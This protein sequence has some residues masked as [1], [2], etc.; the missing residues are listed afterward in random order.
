MPMAAGVS[1]GGCE[2]SSSFDRQRPAVK[3]R[4]PSLEGSSDVLRCNLA[5]G[6]LRH[7]KPLVPGM[8]VVACSWHCAAG[9]TAGSREEPLLT[10]V[11]PHSN[12]ILVGP[13][14]ELRHGSDGPA[15]EPCACRACGLGQRGRGA[16]MSLTSYPFQNEEQRQDKIEIAVQSRIVGGRPCRQALPCPARFGTIRR[17]CNQ[18]AA[19]TRKQP[20]PV[21]AR[22]SRACTPK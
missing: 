9:S 15:W 19:P 12:T 10:N 1:V 5:R 20:T 13:D 4:G 22:D 6:A 17:P 8:G 21:K 3:V 7:N 16:K 14:A 18:K 2:L 11:L